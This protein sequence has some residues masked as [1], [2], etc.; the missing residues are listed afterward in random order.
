[1]FAQFTANTGLKVS[2]HKSTIY[3][4]GG[5][6]NKRELLRILEYREGELSVKYLGLPLIPRILR[7]KECE[8]LIDSISTMTA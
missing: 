1:M 6:T 5:T 8:P 7:D 2:T 3:F 4:S